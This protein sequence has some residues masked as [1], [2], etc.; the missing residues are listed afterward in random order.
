MI[1]MI[2][3]LE[4]FDLFYEFKNKYVSLSMLIIIL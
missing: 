1:M 2:Q 3:G 4:N